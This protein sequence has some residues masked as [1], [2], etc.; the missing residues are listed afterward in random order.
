MTTSPRR[1]GVAAR[2]AVSLLAIRAP[3]V[4]LLLLAHVAVLRA[5]PI[6]ISDSRYV[7]A[8]AV[9]EGD[10]GQILNSVGPSAPFA[11]FD[12]TISAAQT[13]RDSTALSTAFQQSVVTPTHF[14][15]TGVLDSLAEANGTWIGAAANSAF[16]I[17]FELAVPHLYR[18]VGDFER[19]GNG[20]T[21]FEVAFAGEGGLGEG[22]EWG[23]VGILPAGQH[24]FYISVLTEAFPGENGIEHARGSY[25]VDLTLK[26][27]PE[28]A[29]FAL[30]SMGLVGVVV[31]SRW[32]C[33]REKDKC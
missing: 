33:R 5:D 8:Y 16:A 31:R 27:I 25:S 13:A 26:P 1:W 2:S 3:A 28:P 14:A 4:A 15:G 32:R 10:G 7:L 20:F 17:T 30:L 29:S 23:P 11:P 9:R 21:E 12:V 6:L 24:E 18:F 19:S 22:Q